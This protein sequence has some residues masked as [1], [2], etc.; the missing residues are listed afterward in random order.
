MK[1]SRVIPLL[2]VVTIMGTT[3]V[4]SLASGDSSTDTAVSSIESTQNQASEQSDKNN[5]ICNG[6]GIGKEGKGGRGKGKGQK[7]NM[8][9]RPELTEEEKAEMKARRDERLAQDLADGKITQ[10]EYD[11]MINSDF[12]IGRGNR[13]ER[14][15]LTEEEKAEMKAKRDERLA[16]DLA[17][18]KITQ[19]E[20]D[21][22]INCEFDGENRKY[23]GRGFDSENS[24]SGKKGRMNRN[25][26]SD[27]SG[28]NE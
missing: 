9:E 27:Q 4:M 28:E 15:E 5:C 19:E 22:R 1:I 21:E 26:N 24:E 7:G 18:G 10:E 14:P 13:G 12:Q 6:N 23:K 8:S 25:I 20:Y 17:D 16:Q 11:E 3:G 2:G